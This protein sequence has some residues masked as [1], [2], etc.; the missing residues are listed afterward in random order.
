[1][2]SL[3]APHLLFTSNR[4]GTSFDLWSIEVREGKA[5]GLPRLVRE[6]GG[7][8]SAVGMTRSGSYY[9]ENNVQAIGDEIFVQD[10]DSNGK[11]RGTP[12]RLTENFPGSNMGPAWSHDGNSIAFK[13]RQPGEDARYKIVVRSMPTGQ[14]TLYPMESGPRAP[15]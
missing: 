9:Y 1:M 14:E 10:L 13:R 6:E 7:H 12:V 3:T 11:A 8:M 4:K 15:R 5:V 2:D